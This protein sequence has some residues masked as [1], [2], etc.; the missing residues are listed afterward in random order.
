MRDRASERRGRDCL[1][2]HCSGWRGGQYR[3]PVSGSQRGLGEGPVHWRDK[4]GFTYNIIHQLMIFSCEEN[5]LEI[6]TRTHHFRHYLLLL[7][8]IA[9]SAQS[10]RSLP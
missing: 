10:R 8:P 2:P 1:F 5:P 7:L 3:Q 9:C 4:Q 6:A